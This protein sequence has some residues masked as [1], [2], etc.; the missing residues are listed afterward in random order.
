MHGKH[1]GLVKPFLTFCR[2]GQRAGITQLILAAVILFL[3]SPKFYI[4]SFFFLIEQ[5]KKHLPKLEE[6]E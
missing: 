3:I 6:Q 5:I 2:V 1:S 4:M